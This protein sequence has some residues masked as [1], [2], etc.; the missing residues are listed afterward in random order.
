MINPNF[1]RF[2]AIAGVL[3]LLAVGLVGCAGDDTSDIFGGSGNLG[4]Q[5]RVRVFNALQNGNQTGSV[6]VMSNGTS[7]SGS[8][9][10]YGQFS[11]SSGY[12]TVSN[13]TFSPSA[14]TT[15][16]SNV[17]SANG[18]LSGSNNPYTIVVAGDQSATGTVRSQIFTVPDY[19]PNMFTIPSGYTAIRLINLTPSA[20]TSYSLYHTLNGEAGTPL[21]VG[22]ST[23]DVGFGYSGSVNQYALV[24]A[25]QVGALTLRQNGQLDTDLN[26]RNGTLDTFTFQPGR[27]YTIWVYGTGS[28]DAS[29]NLNFRVTQDWP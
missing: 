17:T 9:T 23:N 7:V 5:S 27:A 11:P 19:T 24:Q 12:T 25:N 18:T 21:M 8:S 4:A 3:S 22:M 6:N 2:A 13:N 1:H 10:A 20:N 29:N 28:A 26:F 14:T 15:T 16:G